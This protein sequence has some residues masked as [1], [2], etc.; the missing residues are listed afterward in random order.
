MDEVEADLAA[1]RNDL[2]NRP[3]DWTPDP[4]SMVRQAAPEYSLVSLRYDLCD[5][6]AQRQDNVAALARQTGQQG[7]QLVVSHP[8]PDFC[9]TDS[10]SDRPAAHQLY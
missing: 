9:P 10:S 1:L 6:L 4:W 8:T 2:T 7:I 3:L 5:D